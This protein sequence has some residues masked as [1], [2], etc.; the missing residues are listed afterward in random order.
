MGY[1]CDNIEGIKKD[2]WI[3]L[4][5]VRESIGFYTYLLIEAGRPGDRHI[6]PRYPLRGKVRGSCEMTR[7][8]NPNRLPEIQNKVSEPKKTLCLESPDLLCGLRQTHLR[9]HSSLFV[10]LG[11]KKS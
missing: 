7:K 10:P 11:I 8:W 6:D 1:I 2:T 3:F 5:E 4:H 9:R